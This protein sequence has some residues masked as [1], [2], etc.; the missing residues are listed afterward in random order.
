MPAPHMYAIDW[1]ADQPSVQSKA[2]SR[3]SAASGGGGFSW[4][5]GPN[6]QAAIPARGLAGEIS[7]VS[8]SLQLLQACLSKPAQRQVTL[9]TPL[10][11][12]GLPDTSAAYAAATGL[13]KVASREQ[14]IQ[15][16]RHSI[17]DG[18]AVEVAVLPE[19][20]DAF[21]AACGEGLVA[22][23]RMLP[24]GEP[25]VSTQLGAEFAGTWVVTGGLGDVGKLIGVWAAGLPAVQNV[26]LLGR[27]G[28]ATE[29]MQLSSLQSTSGITAIACDATM[30]SDMTN[31]LQWQ[32]GNAG[33]VAAVF[34][35]GAVLRDAV[36]GRQTGATLRSVYA[37][38]VVGAQHMWTLS[39][40]QPLSRAVYFSSLSAELGTPGQSNYAA[41]NAALESQAQHATNCGVPIGS[42]LWG[43]WANGMALK[44]PA[45]LRRFEKAGLGA[46]TAFSGLHLLSAVMSTVATAA[47]VV[48][49]SVSWN[50]LLQGAPRVPGI[51]AELANGQAGKVTPKTQTTKLAR[52]VTISVDARS[53]PVVQALALPANDQQKG[54][55]MEPV[56]AEIVHSM[57][58][59]AVG[60]DQPLME[61]GLDSLGKHCS[62]FV[63]LPLP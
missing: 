15:T 29:A 56:V 18:Y 31:V 45:V 11:Q 20:V 32:A 58:G 63:C 9:H 54:A 46:I 28:R 43:P 36:I 42:V 47:S 34:H 23:P 10:L 53:P 51:F 55:P 8:A 1:Q 37:P 12:P 30:R 6:M 19:W 38:K 33:P 40:L 25:M 5:F 3:H 50:I 16:F 21:G 7:A 39:H 57:L 26:V 17:Q 48:G 59:H 4:E 35:A 49:A 41:A 61:A 22:R 52:Q 13:M 24:V 44:D 62:Y 27:S 14:S 60:T 2:L